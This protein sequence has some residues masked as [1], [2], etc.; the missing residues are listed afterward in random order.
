MKKSSYWQLIIALSQYEA[1]ESERDAWADAVS[2]ITCFVEPWSTIAI[3]DGWEP[4][5]YTS[6]LGTL[7]EIPST[8]A[9]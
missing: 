2:S 7:G 3:G 4:V 5:L 6:V 1:N 9:L 8:A